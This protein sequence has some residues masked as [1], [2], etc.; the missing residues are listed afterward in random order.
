MRATRRIG[1]RDA[2]GRDLGVEDG[3]GAVGLEAHGGEEG[4]EG[5]AEDEGELAHV[6]APDEDGGAGGEE[7]AGQL[8]ELPVPVLGAVAEEEEADAG[9]CVS[10]LLVDALL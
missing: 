9:R 3:A 6:A 2:V 1:E 7:L 10:L 8:E 4:E 5:E